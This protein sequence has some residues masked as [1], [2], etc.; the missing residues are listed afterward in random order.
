[1]DIIHVGILL[2][3][4]DY[5]YAFC[6]G[7]SSKNI[8]FQFHIGSYRN[9]SIVIMDLED[10]DKWR[11][12]I[13]NNCKC[14]FLDSDLKDKYDDSVFYRYDDLSVISK[15]LLK[16]Y[17]EKRN[18]FSMEIVN[19]HNNTK[20]KKGKTI[21]FFSFYGGCGITSSCISTCE[22]IYLIYGKK[23]I[24]I[25]LQMINDS[26]RYVEFRRDIDFKGLLLHLIA[27]GEDETHIWNV[28]NYIH[29]G[30]NIDY[31]ITPYINLLCKDINIDMYRLLMNK[32][33]N[34]GKY[35]YIFLDIGKINNPLD[36]RII[37]YSN[38]GVTI[39]PIYESGNN[40]FKY[41][42]NNILVD[43]DNIIYANIELSGNNYNKKNSDSLIKYD[44]ESFSHKELMTE[45]NLFGKYGK[46]IWNLMNKIIYKLG[47]LN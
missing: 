7:L 45:I 19:N 2:K 35:D 28:E 13:G 26:Y 16:T 30:E 39:N 4:K 33:I 17:Y 12:I 36:L 18:L 6:K 47:D 44:A 37:E 11:T 22:L 41:I 5:A 3:D 38:C 14:I 29:R 10:R 32:I 46:G 15:V 40:F 23:S 27:E 42:K 24:Y 8:N 34:L 31:L 20:H 43:L 1:M 9:C 25:N 21:T